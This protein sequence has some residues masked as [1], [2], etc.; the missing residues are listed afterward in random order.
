M[1]AGQLSEHMVSII[2]SSSSLRNAARPIAAADECAKVELGIAGPC[3]QVI[4]IVVLR[5]YSGFDRA[6]A[7]DC[8]RSSG[9]SIHC[10]KVSLK[11]IADALEINYFIHQL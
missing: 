10:R 8:I 9:F 3:F 11:E 5:C 2:T 1:K 7:H 4:V 6:A